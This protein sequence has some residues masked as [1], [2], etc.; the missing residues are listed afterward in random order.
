MKRGL[1]NTIKTN[2]IKSDL[3]TGKIKNDCLEQNVFL[4]IRDN[5][6]DLY[7]KGGKLFG[8]E[9][10]VYKTHIKY[11]SVISK[12][13]KDYLTEK[14]LSDPKYLLATDFIKDYK[15]IK[16][17]C[18]NYS[19]LEALG[20]SEIY[21]K[22]SYLSDREIIVL[23]IEVSFSS[24]SQD[25]KQDRIDILLYDKKNKILRF[26]EAKHY[27]NNE[28][29]SKTIPKVVSQIKRYENQI[30]NK[31]PIISEYSNYISTINNIFNLTLPIPEE[32]D[33]KVTLLIF[34]FDDDQKKGKLQTII[35][36]LHTENIKYYAVGNIESVKIESLWNQAKV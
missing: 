27:S 17:N 31:N 14:E 9:Q 12:S 26:V 10:N 15:R 1:E 28:I 22:Y 25:K 29:R 23:D 35:K 19:G 2:L 8:F 20:V 30:K 21:H 13:G 36:Q 6:I 24:P 11:A 16:E 4:T 3:W 18:S 34:G 5:R 32:M 33:N 7:H